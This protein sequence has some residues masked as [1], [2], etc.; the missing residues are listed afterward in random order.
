[1]GGF[2]EY[3]FGGTKKTPNP[4]REWAGMGRLAVSNY[5]DQAIADS[6]MQYDRYWSV[7]TQQLD[8]VENMFAKNKAAYQ[9]SYDSQMADITKQSTTAIED[10]RRRERQG[11]GQIARKSFAS[12]LVGT[13]AVEDWKA[14]LEDRATEAVDAVNDRADKAKMAADAQLASGLAQTDQMYAQAKIDT[15][16][17]APIGPAPW[18]D[19][20]FQK[21][22]NMYATPWESYAADIEKDLGRGLFGDVIV[23]AAVGAAVSGGVGAAMGGLGSFDWGSLFGSAAGNLGAGAIQGQ[24]GGI[25]YA[26]GQGPSG[27]NTGGWGSY[28]QYAG[29]PA[30]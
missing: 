19:L 24:W 16:A 28:G 23:P 2:M 1:M 26:P 20:G 5:Y 9:A 10:I 14:G 27:Y 30:P 13:T 15:L 7:F 11:K 18:I 17:R 29:P 22:Y 4:L 3:M 8:L 6:R 25:P 12:G 21:L